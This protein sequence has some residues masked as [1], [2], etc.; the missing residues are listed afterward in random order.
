MST[1]S[2]RV[3]DL[4]GLPDRA[5]QSHRLTKKDI[6]A[7]WE[8]SSPAD[9]RLLGRVISSARIT[10]VL[11]P[12]T[13]GAAAVET[14]DRRVDMIPVIEINVVDGAKKRDTVRVAE[15]LHRSMPRPSILGLYDE[16]AGTASLSVALTRLS[17][18]DAGR[19]VVEE[20]LIASPERFATGSL[21]IARLSRTDL[22]TLHD[23]LVRA[24]AADGMFPRLSLS[25]AEAIGLRRQ[26]TAATNEL[27]TV[28]RDAAREPSMQRRIDLNARARTLR[29]SIDAL[30]ARLTAPPAPTVP[31]IDPI[32][33]DK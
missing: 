33:D 17:Q 10:A 16:N 21:H 8:G 30:E 7:Q 19:S 23:D 25:A 26:I 27:T 5:R 24:V 32:E 18:T 9:A 22:G 2:M 20:H 3:A 4:L 13:V 12:T 14:P 6:T 29:T 11:S 31:P 15:L 28:A 1:E